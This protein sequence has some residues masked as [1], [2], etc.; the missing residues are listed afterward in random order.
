MEK[1]KENCYNRNKNKEDKKMKKIVCIGLANYDITM[2][3]DT[4]PKENSKNR[5]EEIIECGGGPASTAAYTLGKWGADV[6]FIGMVGNDLYGDRL[7]EEFQKANVN[8]DFLETNDSFSTPVSHIIVSKEKGTRTTLTYR[9]PISMKPIAFQKEVDYI[10]I[11]GQEYEIAKR[12][13]EENKNAISIIDA[14]RTEEK[15]LELCTICNYVICSK[16]FAEK[17]T[18][19]TFDFENSTSIQ[20]IYLKLK[21]KFKGNIIVTLEANGCLYEKDGELKIMT[22]LVVDA[23][24]STG[25]GDIFHGAFTYALANNYDLEKCLQISNTAGAIST[26]RVGGRNSVPTKEEIRE[27]INDFR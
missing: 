10:L 3:V 8:I 15:I 14:G 19:I 18:G 13:I 22:S 23:I 9:K 2:P 1:N 7:K 24:D 11:D 20:N 27:Y 4:Y 6:S 12:M 16:D 21:E 26:K 17:V 5:V 25:A